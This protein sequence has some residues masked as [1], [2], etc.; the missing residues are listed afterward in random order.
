MKAN[1]LQMEELKV[2]IEKYRQAVDSLKTLKREEKT[3]IEKTVKLLEERLNEFQIQQTEQS[4]QLKLLQS[5]MDDLKEA[6][7]EEKE[8]LQ[9]DSIELDKE[10]GR[11]YQQAD[12]ASIPTF[13]TLKKFVNET[14]VLYT[15]PHSLQQ[16]DSNLNR[17]FHR[18]N[19][20]KALPLSDALQIDHSTL[21]ND[22]EQLDEVLE[23]S[24]LETM[25]TNLTTDDDF[26]QPETIKE[27]NVEPEKS[28][29]R[30]SGFWK[31]ILK[32]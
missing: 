6:G 12:L 28:G 3:Q 1:D 4:E 22:A 17:R 20:F 18:K 15:N 29:N 32:K 24:Q 16:E 11:L 2:K 19:Q 27:V 14:P 10:K 8:S 26:I 7:E 9:V 13:K 23:T 5:F 31:G 30:S 21:Q 25:E